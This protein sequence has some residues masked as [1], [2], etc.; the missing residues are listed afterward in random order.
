MLWA[1]AC[2]RS[3][4]ERRVTYNLAEKDDVLATDDEDTTGNVSVGVGDVYPLNRIL[5]HQIGYF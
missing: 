3:K 2:R 4:S 1:C 5:K